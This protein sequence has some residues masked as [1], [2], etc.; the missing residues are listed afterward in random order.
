MHTI[1]VTVTPWNPVPTNTL[2]IWLRAT[3]SE[4]RVG[5]AL[6]GSG[7]LQEQFCFN[8]GETEDHLI[9]PELFILGDRV[10]YDTDR[11]G[12]QHQLETT[13][14]GVEGITVELYGNGDCTGTPL[15]ADVT[16]AVG[17]YLF[18]ELGAGTYC[19]AFSN[20]PADWEIT[21]QD[22]GG[23]DTVDSDANASAQ[24]TNITLSAHDLTQDMGLYRP[25]RIGD[26]VWCDA[27]GEEDF[28]AGEGVPGVTVTL[29]SD[30][31]CNGDESDG[32]MLASTTT[33]ADGYYLFSNLVT[34][35][36]DCG[37]KACYVVK[38]DA[39]D[40]QL[41]ECKLPIT[42]VKH[43]TALCATHFEDL[44]ADFGFQ[45]PIS[46]CGFVYDDLNGNGVLDPGEPPIPD[47][48]IT[49]EDDQGNVV[50]Q[51]ATD[52]NGGYCFYGYRAGTYF[53]TE[54]DP[55]GYVSTNSLPGTGG[56]QENE[57]R[58][59]VDATTPGLTYRT[60]DFLD[61][62]VRVGGATLATNPLRALLPWAGLVA[63]VAALAAAGLVWKVSVARRIG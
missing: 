56:S 15:A 23:D 31:N 22:Q 32:V 17:N 34:G 59:R 27:D 30:P 58:I 53:V 35:P 50:A 45:E 24:I 21:A 63:L 12:I 33:G 55:E 40:E 6:G 29:Y 61:Y 49:L 5:G 18:T 8:D 48:L 54:T 16:D 51:A 42:P 4:Q 13:E 41:G 52:E 14:P 57:N 28:D 60:Q 39:E 44:E 19:I 36:P 43:A 11:D 10:W 26:T 7:G 46:I 25:G 38:V 1:S 3:L 47:V 37:Q 62:R 2:P 20:I 9:Q